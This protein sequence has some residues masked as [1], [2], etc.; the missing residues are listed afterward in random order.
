M[1]HVKMIS[2]VVMTSV[3]LLVLA[4]CQ[5][6]EGPAEQAGKEIDK[7]TEKVE[8]QADKAGKEVGN[9]VDKT[10]EKLDKAGER[11]QESVAPAPQ[12]KAKKD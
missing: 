10:G 9:A 3:L 4:A 6:A 2:A 1:K 11:I 12:D 7:A 5:K 8:V